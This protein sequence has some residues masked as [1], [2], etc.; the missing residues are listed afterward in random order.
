MKKNTTIKTTTYETPFDGFLVDIVEQ[1]D[2][3]ANGE[4]EPMYYAWLYHKDYGVKDL[5]FGS[6]A[7]QHQ[8]KRDFIDMVE[9]NLCNQNYIEGYMEDH[10]D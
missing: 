5:M 9:A 1:T 7:K 2:T 6:M 10:F 8:N 4:T 3:F